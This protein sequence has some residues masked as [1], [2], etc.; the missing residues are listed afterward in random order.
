VHFY[1]QQG[2]LPPAGSPGPG[3]RYDDDHLLRLKVIRRLQRRHLPLAEIRRRLGG[4][5]AA[6]LSQVLQ[7]TEE[8]AK[9]ARGESALDYIRGVLREEDRL[10]GAP[11]SGALALGSPAAA[12]PASRAARAAW[13]VARLT[14]PSPSSPS[15]DHA[16]MDAAAPPPDRGLAPPVERSQ[17]DRLAL[18]PDIELHV[19]R[20]LSRDMNR[21]VER[22]LAAARSI[23]EE[24]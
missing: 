2:L 6:E 9:P 18:A 13:S 24:D 1:I 19:R 4:L 8:R 10:P 20:P 22:L 15:A 7:D 3:A 11:A 21:R 23:M 14:G 12:S 17:W 16:F 5:A